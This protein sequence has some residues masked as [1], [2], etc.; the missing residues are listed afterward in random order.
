MSGLSALVEHRYGIAREL[1]EE[2][3]EQY[4]AAADALDQRV[5]NSWRPHARSSRNVNLPS[6]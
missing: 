2:A 4:R 1:F 6:A 3:A 5:S